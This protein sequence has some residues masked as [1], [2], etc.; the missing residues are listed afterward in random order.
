MN[1]KTNLALELICAEADTRELA[2]VDERS[3]LYFA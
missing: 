1:G 2:R 3:L